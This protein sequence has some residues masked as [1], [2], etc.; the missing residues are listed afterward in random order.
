MIPS[1]S[2][3]CCLQMDAKDP[4]ASGP[5]PPAQG[6]PGPTRLTPKSP[7]VSPDV[8]A[9]PLPHFLPFTQ[10]GG[11]A[12]KDDRAKNNWADLPPQSGAAPPSH[13]APW[14]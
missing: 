7:S 10:A 9:I 1:P 5:K 2:R 13:L 8:T 3:S 6:A 4:Q 12:L 14:R 11:G